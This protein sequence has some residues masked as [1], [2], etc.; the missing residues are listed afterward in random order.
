M[1][2]L[3]N[4]DIKIFD[5]H[6]AEYHEDIVKNLKNCEEQVMYGDTVSDLLGN[7]GTFKDV[8]TDEEFPDYSKFL[9]ETVSGEIKR[10]SL[11]AYLDYRR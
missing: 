3:Q 2:E 8:E 4:L 9:V 11:I 7:F 1:M 10:C 5:I 6:D